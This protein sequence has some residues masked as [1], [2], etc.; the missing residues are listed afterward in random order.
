MP[1]K[2]RRVGI[3][4]QKSYDDKSLSGFWT[5]YANGANILDIGFKG[6]IEGC[7]PIA[8]HAIGV[9]LDY[10]GYDGH[11]LPFENESQDTVYSSHCLEHIPDDVHAIQ[12][13]FR[14]LKTNGHIIVVVP[15]AYLYERKMTIPHSKWNGDHKRAYTPGSLLSMIERALV[16][17]T[18]RVRHLSDNDLNYDYSRTFDEHPHGCYEIDCVI[19]KIISPIWPVQK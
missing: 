12:D 11:T 7:G 9:D 4:T 18:Y 6:H 5:L 10:P 19:Q 8:E 15:H 1:Y 2:D 13:W 16:P 17:N 14:V 3:E